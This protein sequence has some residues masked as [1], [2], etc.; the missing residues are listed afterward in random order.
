MKAVR[1]DKNLEGC[2]QKKR[3]H[4][5]ENS[6][7][8]PSIVNESPM[9]F[10]QGLSEYEAGWVKTLL[11]SRHKH[12]RNAELTERTSSLFSLARRLAPGRKLWACAD[13]SKAV[14]AW[15]RCFCGNVMLPRLRGPQCPIFSALIIMSGIGCD[16]QWTCNAGPSL[17]PTCLEQEREHGLMGQSE[18]WSHGGDPHILRASPIHHLLGS[19]YRGVLFMLTLGRAA[20]ASLTEQE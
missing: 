19:S 20:T 3:F 6:P 4:E 1:R 9:D 8:Q 12:S 2:F 13:A 15:H 10:A 17:P 5:S 14:L 16:G 18:L 11:Y 7:P